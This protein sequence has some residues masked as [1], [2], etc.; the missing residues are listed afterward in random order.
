MRSSSQQV[1]L[2]SFCVRTCGPALQ[3]ALEGG[4]TGPT[5]K[6]FCQIS[7]L[8]FIFIFKKKCASG[9][10][11]W[12]RNRH[13]Y[14]ITR[15]TILSCIFVWPSHFKILNQFSSARGLS[16]R[17]SYLDLAK[18]RHFFNCIFCEH[19]LKIKVR[20][21]SKFPGYKRQKQSLSPVL[22]K[23]TYV[24]LH[25]RVGA[26]A[27]E[28]FVLLAVLLDDLAGA[29]VVTSQHSSHHHK[30]SSCAWGASPSKLVR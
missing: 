29:L 6:L 21:I 22:C 10:V 2:L 14:R 20:F 12:N 26:H 9:S 3:N 7:R 4:A 15:E 17:K 27:V 5:P 13:K 19:Q 1:K 18:V 23:P 11:N 16:R 25:G 30:V 8:L 28:E 24:F